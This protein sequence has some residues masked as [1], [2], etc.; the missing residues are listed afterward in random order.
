M[1]DEG[2]SVITEEG[3]SVTSDEEVTMTITL[4]SKNQRSN[5]MV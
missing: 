1:S 2:V 3:A 4:L 5:D